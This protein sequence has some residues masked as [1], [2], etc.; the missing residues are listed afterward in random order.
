MVDNLKTKADEIEEQR[1][2]T[3]TEAAKKDIRKGDERETD[4]EIERLNANTERLNQAIARN[5]EAKAKARL[6][7]RSEA[8]QE[9]K[10]VTQ[11]DKDK[12]DV[13]KMLNTFGEQ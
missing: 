4:E 6:G 2:E 11:E 7:G 3:P 8:G 1:K 5:D 12:E 10:E 9:V 13:D